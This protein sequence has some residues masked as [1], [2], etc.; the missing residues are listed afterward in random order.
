[1]YWDGF[2]FLMIFQ[3]SFQFIE[4]NRLGNFF[5][6]GFFL[7]ISGLQPHNWSKP[8]WLFLNIY[9]L[10]Y[11]YA[12][13]ASSL[14][15]NIHKLCGWW[16]HEVVRYFHHLVKS[17]SSGLFFGLLIKLFLDL[18]LVLV[19]EHRTS[20]LVSPEDLLGPLFPDGHL[21][22]FLF[23]HGLCFVIYSFENIYFI[24]QSLEFFCEVRDRLLFFCLVNGLPDV[25]RQLPVIFSFPESS[26]IMLFLFD[27]SRC[28]WWFEEIIFWVILFLRWGGWVIFKML[29]LLT[30]DSFEGIRIVDC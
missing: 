27:D 20:S 5:S 11:I 24:I 29:I 1:M 12:R 4:S 22:E 30:E 16:I 14:L 9:R 15:D 19:V 10:I 13:L 17:L 18:L 21:F 6:H 2:I 23:M 7:V 26:I 3:I 25:G 28:F 8:G